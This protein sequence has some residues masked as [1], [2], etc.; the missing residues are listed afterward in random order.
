MEHA[1]VMAFRAVE[2]RLAVIRNVNTGIG[3]VID[4]FGRIRDRYAEGNLPAEAMSRTGMEGWFAERIPIDKRTTFFSKYGEWLD[5]C[6]E[7][8]VILRIIGLLAAK[9]FRARIW[10]VGVSRRSNE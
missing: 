7:L 3:C 8:C 9:V 10:K 6:C 4:S 1:A 5:F 2:D